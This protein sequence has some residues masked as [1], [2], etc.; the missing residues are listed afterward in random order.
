LVDIFGFA[1]FA[2][3]GY[4]LNFYIGG[5]SL[6]DEEF[7][8]DTFSHS[9]SSSSNTSLKKNTSL[10][11]NVKNTSLNKNVKNT[12]LNKDVKNISQEK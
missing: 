8:Y 6:S 12:S 5:T 4:Y 7:Q 2:L 1:L 3:F 10:N 9:C 11:K